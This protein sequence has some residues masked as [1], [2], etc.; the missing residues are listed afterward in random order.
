[1]RSFAVLAT[2]K[3]KNLQPQKWI[4]KTT[5]KHAKIDNFCGF[6]GY[7]QSFT[8]RTVT[9]SSD[10]AST[11][12]NGRKPLSLTYDHTQFS[13][14]DCLVIIKRFTG[15]GGIDLSFEILI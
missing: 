10:F 13:V 1:M 9:E 2:K 8:N 3:K 4:A 12:Q 11:N 6:T 7:K 5:K 14:G 15:I